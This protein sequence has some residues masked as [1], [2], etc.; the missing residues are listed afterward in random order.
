MQACSVLT[1]VQRPRSV[2]TEVQRPRSCQE[3]F[4][5]AML[6]Q[7]QCLP[8]EHLAQCRCAPFCILMQLLSAAADTLHGSICA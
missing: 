7:Y 6:V 5:I 3:V 1:E 8:A 4:A 2:L